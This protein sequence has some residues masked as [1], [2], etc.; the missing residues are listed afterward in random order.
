MLAAQ[1]GSWTWEVLAASR[2]IP[3][4]YAYIAVVTSRIK[5]NMGDF[6]SMLREQAPSNL[7]SGWRDVDHIHPH[8]AH[9]TSRV[10]RTYHPQFGIPVGAQL[11]PWDDKKR[12][13]NHPFLLT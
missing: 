5:I 4:S 12:E 8:E 3:G 9:L 1:I 7:R 11:D 6:E 2:D 10:K 13:S